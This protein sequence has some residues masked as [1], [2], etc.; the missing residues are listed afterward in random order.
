MRCFNHAAH[1]KST[2]ARRHVVGGGE[3]LFGHST[4]QILV[5]LL[6]LSRQKRVIDTAELNNETTQKYAL[7]ATFRTVVQAVDVVW[8]LL[9]AYSLSP[10]CTASTCTYLL[11]TSRDHY[12]HTDLTGS[13]AKPCGHP[14]P[15]IQLLK[16]PS[17]KVSSS[18]E[19][20]ILISFQWQAE[21][22]DQRSL[23]GRSGYVLR[24]DSK[25]TLP[26]YSRK[27]DK[28]C[29]PFTADARAQATVP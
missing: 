9:F 10:V 15:N 25:P 26:L 7:E 5:L 23:R 17:P 2:E 12:S 8:I 3:I 11:K 29:S 4:S 6:I 1:I 28:G 14:R 22:C 13:T 19:L 24:G 21:R 18:V 27:G 16:C 20:H